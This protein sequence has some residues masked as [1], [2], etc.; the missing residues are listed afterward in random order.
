MLLMFNA[1]RK[2]HIAGLSPKA[3]VQN[4]LIAVQI[5]PSQKDA[6]VFVTDGNVYICCY[7]ISF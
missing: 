7:N 3:F 5:Y 1:H 4:I 2:Y 6:L